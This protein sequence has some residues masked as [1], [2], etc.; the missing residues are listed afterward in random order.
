MYPFIVIALGIA[1]LLFGNRLAVLGAAVGGL[2]GVVL[3]QFFPEATLT[4]QLLIV[5]GLALGGFFAAAFARGVIEVVI[6]VIGAL[7]GAAAVLLF[8]NL[9]NIEQGLLNWLLAVVGGVVGLMLIRRSRRGSRDW[10][11][12]LLAD[13]VGALLILRG[14]VLLF[15]LQRN[16]TLY[17]LILLGLL[18]LGFIFQGGYLRGRKGAT[19]APAVADKPAAAPPVEAKAT[20]PPV[21][22]V[23]P[24]SADLPPT[25]VPPVTPVAPVPPPAPEPPVEPPNV[26]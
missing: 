3:L 2:L 15:D 22:P 19:P 4:T 9:F 13:L 16:T 7:G 6:L 20:M 12:V 24:A 5:L 23:P 10:G 14:L 21:T 25:P 11:M 18:V 17:T 26:A 1:V 8:L